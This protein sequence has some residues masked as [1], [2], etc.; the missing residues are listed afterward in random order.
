MKSRLSKISF[1]LFVCVV[2]LAGLYFENRSGTNP[3]TYSND[4]NVYF[5]AARELL[6]GRTP[7]D[8]SLGPWT[9]Y[10]YLPVLAELLVL[11]A[12]LPL[13]VAAYL[14]FLLSALFIFF[15]ARWSASLVKASDNGERQ[16]LLVAISLIGLTRFILD[17][18]DYGQVN[19]IVTGLV[20]AHLYFYAKERKIISATALALAAAIKL[21]PLIFIAYHL[22]RR[23]VKFAV[24]C[25]ALF[26]GLGALSFAPFGSRAG[27]AYG[28]FFKRTVRNEQR[29][30]L[31]YHGNQ[32]LRAVLER[33]QGNAE[34][35][36]PSSRLTTVISASLLFLAFLVAARAADDIAAS[37]PFFCLAVF[38]SPL[39]WKQHFVM[40]ILPVAFLAHEALGEKAK[41]RK[42]ILTGVLTVVFALFNLASPKLIGIAAAEWCDAHSFIFLGALLLYLTVVSQV[43]RA[44]PL[45]PR[46]V[47]KLTVADNP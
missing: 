43:W 41:A 29:F 14:W 36:E 9:P 23:R 15:A 28:N 16:R 40:L 17:N 46:P 4:F 39:S 6:A 44:S 34:V 22:A 20:V 7:Y 31:A 13:P 47:Q 35:T 26:V 1:L 33:W 2:L 21:T 30:N 3:N 11:L 38:L 32:S 27:D 25:A 19:L 45:A 18:F 5:F 10:L 42:V 12:W 24:L 37:T 8:N